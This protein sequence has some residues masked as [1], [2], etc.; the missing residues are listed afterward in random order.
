MA[1][2][3]KAKKGPVAPK[4]PAKKAVK[5]TVKKT[6]KKKS[7][8]K[9]E[10]SIIRKYN[11]EVP[12]ELHFVLSDGRRVKNIFELID[13]LDN[14]NDEIFRFHVGDQNNDFS[15]W[16][17]D[18]FDEKQLANKLKRMTSKIEAQNVLLKHLIEKL[19]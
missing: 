15:N 17:S 6:T 11:Q 3:K 7:K 12:Y 9:I 14:M 1:V 18:V 5:K 4:K 2:K 8:N 16:L 10:V 13:T 19:K